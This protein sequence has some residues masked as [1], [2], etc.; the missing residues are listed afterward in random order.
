MRANM[1]VAMMARQQQQMTSPSCHLATDSVSVAREWRLL[2]ERFQCGIC[3]G[4]LA[5][6]ALTACGHG[7]D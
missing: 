6:R 2:C 1:E 7:T 5:G 4:L 3:R